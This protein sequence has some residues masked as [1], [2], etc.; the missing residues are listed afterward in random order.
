MKNPEDT[1]DN[2]DSIAV[3]PSLVHYTLMHFFLEPPAILA[4]Y[5]DQTRRYYPSNM[6]RAAVMVMEDTGEHLGSSNL[7]QRLAS[8][9]IGRVGTERYEEIMQSHKESAEEQNQRLAQQ[10]LTPEG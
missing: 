3:D 10:Q 5:S 1:V 7:I 4:G 6:Q 2:K 8:A 9:A